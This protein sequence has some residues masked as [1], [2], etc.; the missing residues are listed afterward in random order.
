MVR[1]LSNTE[2]LFLENLRAGLWGEGNSVIRI[3]GTADWEKIYQLAQEQSVQGLVLQGIEWFKNHNDNPNL[4]VNIPKILLLQWIGDVQVIE[5]RNKEMNA[6]V[7]ELIEKLRKNDIYAILVKGQGIAQC[8]EIPLWR[9]CGDVDLLLLSEDYRKAFV[10]FRNEAILTSKDKAKNRERL[11][12]EFQVKDWVLELHGTLH[13]SLS[14]KMDK[15]IDSVQHEVFTEEKVRVWKNGEVDVTIPAPNEDIIFVFSHILQHFFFGGIGLR[16]LC[17]LCRL[18]WTYR[19]SIDQNLLCKRLQ[20][21]GVVT[22]WK[23]FV[24]LMVEHLGL[25]AEAAPLYESGY[26]MKA[27]RALSYTLEVG[28]FGHNRDSSYLKE[29]SSIKRK[30]NILLHQM[31]DSLRLAKI[32][33]IDAWLFFFRTVTDGVKNT[34]CVWQ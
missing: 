19:D 12:A 6:F 20:K 1:K 16:Q 28:N 32:F 34:I 13:A 3:D 30:S 18:L 17:D 9:S 14:S 33:P 8:Y 2:G 10:L 4:N 15:V 24:A 26:E 11:N 5:Q 31:K 21:M 27:E 23:V 22:E 29:K 7:A 25:P